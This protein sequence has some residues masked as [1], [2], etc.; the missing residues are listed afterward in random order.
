MK[1]PVSRPKV[2][3]PPPA[4]PAKPYPKAKSML[5]GKKGSKSC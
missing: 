2:T 1:K 5:A 4:K 3:P